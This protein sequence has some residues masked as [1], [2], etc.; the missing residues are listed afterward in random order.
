MIIF[1]MRI[2]IF[3]EGKGNFVMMGKRFSIRQGYLRYC[4]ER[5]EVIF[6]DK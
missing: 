1:F 6:K 4:E 5:E 3:V 2:N